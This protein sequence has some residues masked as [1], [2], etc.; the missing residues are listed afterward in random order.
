MKRFALILVA[1]MALPLFISAQVIGHENVVSH[2]TAL[3]CAQIQVQVINSWAG[4]KC[5]QQ[6]DVA[7]GMESPGA[8]GFL[9]TINYVD[10]A[11]NSLTASQFI[12]A[13]VPFGAAQWPP[14][15]RFY[16]DDITLVSVTIL[17][18]TAVPNSS[19]T[20]TNVH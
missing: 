19:V 15:A 16:L 7:V 14:V 10:H 17:P 11:S 1:S 3:D 5:Q 9:V 12:S 18:L 20:I 2:I 13:T 6:V 8:V 4:Q